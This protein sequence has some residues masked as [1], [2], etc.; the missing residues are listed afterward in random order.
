ML[1][2]GSGDT[3]RTIVF[4]G[5]PARVL[6]T[7]Y[8]NGAPHCHTLLLDVPIAHSSLFVMQPV[9]VCLTAREQLREA[10]DGAA[11]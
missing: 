7:P 9:F 10:V 1:E 11:G 5:R 8:A 3:A 4:T 2:C 6:K